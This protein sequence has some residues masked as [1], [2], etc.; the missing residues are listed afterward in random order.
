MAFP[1]PATDYA[2]KE[3]CLNE[4]MIDHPSDTTM[5]QVPGRVLVVDLSLQ[6]EQG[7]K[8]VFELFGSG[9]IGKAEQRRLNH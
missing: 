9:Y 4:L 8:A 6:P 3:L 7:D 2:Q 1:S 5:I